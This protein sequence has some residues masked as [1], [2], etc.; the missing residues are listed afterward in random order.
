MRALR[1]CVAGGW[2][3]RSPRA[4]QGVKQIEERLSAVFFPSVLPFAILIAL[5]LI[6]IVSR[7]WLT[8]KPLLSWH[9]GF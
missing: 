9:P 7:V 1:S 8:L 3:R 6:S 5:S 4:R 2:L